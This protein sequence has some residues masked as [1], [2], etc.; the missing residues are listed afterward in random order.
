MKLFFLVLFLSFI[1]GGRSQFDSRF[2]GFSAYQKYDESFITPSLRGKHSISIGGLLGIYGGQVGAAFG[3][4]SNGSSGNLN[5]QSESLDGSPSLGLHIG[6]NYLVLDRRKLKISRKD[7]YR[8]EFLFILGG[9]LNVLTNNEFMVMGTF[10]HQ[11]L[12]T[13]G[14]LFSWTFFSEYGIGFHRTSTRL[15]LE[16][17][18]KIDLSIELFRMR[19]VKQPLYLFGQFCYATSNDFLSKNAANVGFYGGL[20]YYFYKRKA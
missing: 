13:K 12:G 15:Q 17:P 9:H 8:D 11:L 2:T 6:Y 14:R 5:G 20:R 3:A 16:K 18:L 4:N 7:K 19:F 10:Y 1:L